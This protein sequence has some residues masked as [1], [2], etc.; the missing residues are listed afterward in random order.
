[1][2]QVIGKVPLTSLL[3]QER[4]KI[5]ARIHNE[6][7]EIA[8]DFGIIVKEVRIVS[9]NLPKENSNAIFERMRA[10]RMREAELFRAEG[11]KA[12]QG[13]RAAADRTRAVIIAEASKRAQLIRGAGDAKA[14]KVYSEAF[15]QDAS[16]FEF[17]WTLQAYGDALKADNTTF[18]LSP[19]N[20]FLKYL[21]QGPSGS[22]SAKGQH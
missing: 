6:V 2:R 21:E 13:I 18:I 16:L 7:R 4:E 12:A 15:S 10:E 8:K 3:S 5:M 19:E 22:F 20:A 11:K 14:I 1:M 17:L 9:A